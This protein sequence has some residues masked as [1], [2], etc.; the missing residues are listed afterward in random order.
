LK[1][2]I[3]EDVINNSLEYS[4]LFSME[5][6]LLPLNKID[7]NKEVLID[8]NKEV[9][10]F[11]KILNLLRNGSVTLIP[12]IFDCFVVTEKFL[13]FG[14]EFQFI[15]ESHII[16][17]NN[18]EIGFIFFFQHFTNNDVLEK[19]FLD[20][21]ILVPKIVFD[22]LTDNIMYCIE[23]LKTYFFWELLVFPV[24]A[25]TTIQNYFLQKYKNSQD[26]V[27]VFKNI[28]KK[29]KSINNIQVKHILDFLNISSFLYCYQEQF[30]KDNQVI[31]ILKYIKKIKNNEFSFA[32]N[33]LKNFL[34]KSINRRL[35]DLSSLSC[36]ILTKKYFHNTNLEYL[37]LVIVFGN[38][39]AN[40][41]NFS[42]YSNIE[43]TRIGLIDTI[44]LY[45]IINYSIILSNFSLLKK[46]IFYNI[47][48]VKNEKNIRI[49]ILRNWK[50]LTNSG[51]FTNRELYALVNNCSE[52]KYKSDSD[53][54]SVL[55]FIDTSSDSDSDSNSVSDSD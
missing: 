32:V 10:T 7:E 30:F 3:F 34:Y 43:K 25:V 39:I 15:N 46:I 8:E 29:I 16:K 53:S 42:E 45:G 49:L 55:S 36:N 14:L 18:K 52:E 9:L 33:M 23:V 2:N 21:K 47:T 6:Q 13:E 40:D 4:I 44:N 41:F 12:I 54:D 17:L 51:F 20:L 5:Q 27:R 35:I 19:F 22:T 37:T 38:D 24:N 48:D 26:A 28:V 1:N 11:E 50:K 31:D